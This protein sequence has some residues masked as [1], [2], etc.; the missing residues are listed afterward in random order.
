ML[1]VRCVINLFV[2]IRHTMWRLFRVRTLVRPRT[3]WPKQWHL[4]WAFNFVFFL[5]V[6]HWRI[7]ASHPQPPHT[8]HTRQS[9]IFNWHG[10][11]VSLSNWTCWI[12][13]ASV[14]PIHTYQRICIE[15]RTHLSVSLIYLS[16]DTFR[17][18]NKIC[19]WKHGYPDVWECALRLLHH[20]QL[21]MFIDFLKS[22]QRS[23]SGRS[24]KWIQS[25]STCTSNRISIRSGWSDDEKLLSTE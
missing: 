6:A 21:S 22:T 2:L 12:F 8:H 7:C 11:V 24:M 5:R 19:I 1:I 16:V 10:C 25:S 15:N 23:D 13:V 14:P 18:D 17:C 4:I 3:D 20:R 9:F